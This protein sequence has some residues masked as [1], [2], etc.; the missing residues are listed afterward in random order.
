MDCA[1]DSQS[2]NLWIKI[3]SV[4]RFGL[5]SLLALMVC[6]PGSARAE[7]ECVNVFY[8]RGPSGYW[9]GK[10]Y[11]VFLQN[12]LGHFPEFQQIVSPIELYQKGDIDR[13]RASFYIGSYFYSEIPKEFLEDYE[14][15]PKTVAWLGYSIWKTGA[16]FEKIFG[17]VYDGE[18]ELN[19]KVQD[20]NGLPSFFRFIEYKGETFFKFAEWSKSEPRQFE[21]AYE[22]VRLRETRPGRSQVLAWAKHS[23]LPEKIPYILQAGRRFYVADVPFSFIH[24]ADRYLVMADLLFDILNVPPKRKEKLALVRVEDVHPKVPLYNLRAMTK[25]LVGEQIPFV[26]SLIPIFFDPFSLYDRTE[27]EE[28]VTM[29]RKPEFLQLLR[30]LPRE[31]VSFIWHGVTH[32]H[33]REKNPFDGISGADFEFWDAKKNSSIREDN[34]TWLVNRLNDGLRVLL[35]AK[36]EPPLAWL[37]PHYQASALDYLIFARVFPWNIGRVIYFDFQAAHLPQVT[38]D[39]SVWLRESSP[40]ANER[41]VAAFRALRVD[42]ASSRWNG[43]FFPY[44]IYGDVY[45]QRVVPENLGDS[46]PY[47]NEFVIRTRTVAEMVADAKRNRVIR[48]AWASFF[49]HPQLLEVYGQSG[50]GAFPGDPQELVYLV[51]ELKKLGY[52]FV[53]LNDFIRNQ[54]TGLRPEPFYREKV[55]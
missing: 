13:C 11:A 26:M 38:I 27:L 17:H 6:W 40:V 8:D 39:P 47:I 32:Q 18:T 51:R 54:T 5:A 33:G 23:A 10:T 1:H 31:K 24:E 43:Q 21:A 35:N 12:L 15:S 7:A 9:M 34:P 29:D 14:K 28:F 2:V 42:L 36:I 50:R 30:E 53:H 44:E 46:Q 49:Y 52:R 55:L 45:G 25:A 48:D 41:R 22:Q 4:F 20:A 19:E 37:T 16:A 3:D